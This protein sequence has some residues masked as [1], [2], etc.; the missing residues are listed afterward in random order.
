PLR[1]PA[2]EPLACFDV[3]RRAGKV[4]VTGKRGPLTVKLGGGG[5]S[6]VVLVGAGTETL[7]RG[8]YGR[9]IPLLGAEATPPVDRPNLSKDYLAGSAPE[10]WLTLRDQ[11]FYSDN[12][13]DLRLNMAVAAIDVRGRE[14]TPA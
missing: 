2:L 5:P 1:A 3:A 11:S 8:G 7:R 14:A 4:V 10:E 12:A 6:S 13:I 9:P